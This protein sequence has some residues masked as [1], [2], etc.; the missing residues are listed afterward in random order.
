VSLLEI[1]DVNMN[2]HT[3]NGVTEAIKNISFNIE[4]GDFVSIVGPSGCGKSTLLNIISGLLEP[5]SGEVVYNDPDVKNNLDK[6]GYMF[7]KDYLFPWLTVRENVLL[8]LKIKG[9]LTVDNIERA[10]NLLKNYDLEKFKDHKPT[11]L[12][13]GMRQRVALIRTLALNPRILLLDEPFSALDYQTRQ[14]LTDDVY[15][16]IKREG[17]TAIM[18]THDIGEAIIMSKRVIVL[19]KRPATIKDDMKIVFA[20]SDKTPFNKRREPEFNKYFSKLWQEVDGL[21]G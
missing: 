3:K 10:D 8:G 13:G 11:Q 4:E 20:N 14:K 21:N 18:V 16:I 17:K 15:E 2:Y 1:K 19:T 12:S 6:M 7:Q 9:F 5:S